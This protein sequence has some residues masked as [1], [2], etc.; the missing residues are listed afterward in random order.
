MEPPY[1]IQ[2]ETYE[3]PLDLLLDLIR[4]QEINIYDIPIAR[5]TAQYLEYVQ[6][7]LERLDTEAAGE[8]LLMAATLIHIKS[9]MLLPPDPASQAEEADPR[10]EL[11]HQLLE[12]EKF[13]R[14]AQMLQQKHLL[15]SACWSAPGLSQFLDPDAE[16]ELA[17]SLFDL[18]KAFQEVL[19]RAKERPLLDI[20]QEKVSVGDMMRHLCELLAASAQPLALQEILGRLRSRDAIVAAFLALLEL[21]RLQAVAIR[22]NELFAEIEIRKHHGFA[23]AVASLGRSSLE[24]YE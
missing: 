15:Q 16:Q 18:V 4:K 10:A 17:V 12:H 13:K 23:D 14:A 19:E 22:Q 5:I 24:E 1:N 7:N 20:E 2:L 8:F 9:K 21:V 3:G 11:V 6:R